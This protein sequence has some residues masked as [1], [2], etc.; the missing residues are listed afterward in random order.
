MINNISPSTLSARASAAVAS[1]SVL[2]T[3]L[4]SLNNIKKQA[5]DAALKQVAKQFESM[6]VGMLFKGMRQ[7]NAVF[8][9][10][11]WNI[12]AS[13]MYRDMHISK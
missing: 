12:N 8:E 7:A 6:F 2:Y 4:N 11:K 9:Q 10:G 13:H 1:D 3:D 5:D